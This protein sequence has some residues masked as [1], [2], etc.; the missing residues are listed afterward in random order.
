MAMAIIIVAAAVILLTGLASVLTTQGGPDTDGRSTRATIQAVTGLTLETSPRVSYTNQT[1]TFYANATS[2]TGANLT[3]RINFE[4]R[5][6]SGQNNSNSPYSITTT[7]SP[8]TAVFTYAYNHSGYWKETST[9]NMYLYARVWCSDGELTVSTPDTK[10]YVNVNRAPVVAPGLPPVATS[11]YEDQPFN[12]TVNVSDP[13]NDTLTVFWEFGDG[14]NATNILT[15]TNHNITVNQTHTYDPPV[16]GMIIEVAYNYTLNLTVSDGWGHVVISNTT[17]PVIPRQNWFALAELATDT[18]I[19]A[20]LVP[21]TITANATDVEGDPLTWTFI[22][23]D[24]AGGTNNVSV[25]VYYTPQSLPHQVIW[26]NITY[27]FPYV[28]L[29]R[30]NLYVSDVALPFQGPD[31]FHN[32]TANA[33]AFTVY[34]NRVPYVKV[35]NADPD[36]PLINTTSANYVTVVLSTDTNDEDGDILNATWDFGDGSP[37]EYNESAG[38]VMVMYHFAQVHNYT[39]AGAYNVTVTITDGHGHIVVQSRLLNVTSNNRPPVVKGFDH[40][41]YQ[42]G[43]FAT[44]NE[45]LEFE[46]VLT[47]HERDRIEVKWDFGDGSPLV[48]TNVTDF[49]SSGNVTI[50]LTHAYTE[51]GNYTVTI[52]IDDFKKS[53][54]THEKNYSLPIRVWIKPP[55]ETTAWNWW[56]YTSLGLVGMIPVMLGA[57]VVRMRL[58]HKLMEKQGMSYDEWKLRKQLEKESEGND[59]SGK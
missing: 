41:P 24:G 22:V 33:L 16:P 46:L 54:L 29:F 50:T 40:Q 19:V 59:D 6:P 43:D 17:V 57:W 20:P 39:D 32:N 25:M 9:S 51:K 8:G 35:I 18:L 26:H 15:G 45:I 23:T 7:T 53:A 48:Y 56:D 21:V 58:R 49:G 52:Y 44:P 47:D 2:T 42:A 1:V 13:D 28:G 12:F 10:V 36:N 5:L 14:T 55:V 30:L 31:W 34:V 38:G 4:S 3:F 27:E 11:Q 37:P